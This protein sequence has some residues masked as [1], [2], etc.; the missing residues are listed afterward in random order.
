M[1]FP[2]ITEAIL[3]SVSTLDKHVTLSLSSAI[4]AR[5]FIP[6]LPPT[7][8]APLSIFPKEIP[9]NLIRPG[10]VLSATLKLKNSIWEIQNANIQ[11]DRIATTVHG[12]I[13]RHLSES[14][15]IFTQLVPPLVRAP[16]ASA[17]K[18]PNMQLGDFVRLTIIEGKDTKSIHTVYSHVPHLYSSRI[19]LSRQAH[20]HYTAEIWSLL[21]AFEDFTTTMNH[22]RNFLPKFQI[23]VNN[24][25]LPTKLMIRADKSAHFLTRQGGPCSL[26]Y[27]N[28]PLGEATV[29][30]CKEFPD[31]HLEA[32]VQL[33][34]MTSL[35]LLERTHTANPDYLS[36]SPTKKSPTFSLFSKFLTGNK[37]LYAANG[38]S[39]RA[40]IFRSVLGLETPSP[41]MNSPP[42]DSWWIDTGS[43]L[44]PACAEAQKAMYHFLYPTDKSRFINLISIPGSGK[45]EF[46]LS[47]A[48]QYVLKTPDCKILITSQSNSN[49]DSLLDRFEQVIFRLPVNHQK[50]FRLLRITSR[51]RECTSSHPASLHTLALSTY[52]NQSPESVHLQTEIRSVSTKITDILEQIQDKSFAK[53][54]W[55]LMLQLRNFQKEYSNLQEDLEAL[56]LKDYAPTCVFGTP[57]SLQSY[58]LANAR[59]TYQRILCDEASMLTPPIVLLLCRLLAP[60]DSSLLLLGDP[61]QLTANSMLPGIARDVMTTSLIQFLMQ[62]NLSRPFQFSISFRLPPVL[63]EFFASCVYPPG[64]TPFE[65]RSTLNSY[66]PIS[67][68]PFPSDFVPIL[69]IDCPKL[70][71]EP[72]NFSKHNEQERIAAMSV[73]KYLCEDLHISPTDIAFLSTY[74][75]Q[76]RLLKNELSQAQIPQSES[77][78]IGSAEYF[79]GLQAN[80]VI[81]STVRS[82]PSGTRI[83]SD[84]DK[85]K[86]LG[87]LCP[88]RA[89]TC[90]SRCKQALFICSN[91]ETLCLDPFWSQFFSFLKPFNVIVPFHEFFLTRAETAHSMD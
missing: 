29:I 67:F 27:Q 57:I 16:L 25:A 35:N 60:N 28:T 82:S 38:N 1:V 55:H 69:V 10:I 88:K 44:P 26:N 3:L 17:Q 59:F 49:V 30:S 85:R 45:S 6:P 48:C 83:L 72:I 90:L 14:I 7:I 22:K 81:L 73:Y 76:C 37:L 75:A 2:Y 20:V 58:R 74:R 61:Y 41:F 46:L 63:L 18:I 50:R 13:Y 84:I 9:L 24:Y 68:F 65:S 23:Q 71:N 42:F 36:F 66:D 56:V 40:F 77:T 79:Q 33:S 62:N 86:T 4:R 51:M 47:A 32:S 11:T 53:T 12:I 80:I 78:S 31:G 52:P 64:P 8:V 87:F 15:E 89:V 39:S 34:P 19:P 5:S 70:E 54:R 91:V 21:L 43:C